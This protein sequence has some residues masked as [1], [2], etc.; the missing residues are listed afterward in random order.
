MPVRVDT[1]LLVWAASLPR[2]SWLQGC[3]QSPPAPS[4]LGFLRLH[5]LGGECQGARA[6]RRLPTL[7]PEAR[8]EWR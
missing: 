4:Q 2:A 5:H 7:A 8:R 1:R 3:L 6:S